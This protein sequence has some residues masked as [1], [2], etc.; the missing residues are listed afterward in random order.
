MKLKPWSEPFQERPT[1]L[2]IDQALQRVLSLVKQPLEAEWLTLEVAD[3]RVL[4]ADIHST[5]V[6]PPF[7]NSA[8]DGYALRS[9]D[10]NPG[11]VLKIVEETPAGSVSSH[12][13]KPGECIRIFT[14]APV[15]EGC[16]AVLM[17]EDAERNGDEMTVTA[18]GPVVVGQHIRRRGGDVEDGSV[19]VRAGTVLTPGEI[20]LL[21]SCG[22][23]GVLVRRRPRVAIVSTGHEL[24]YIDEK[25]APGQIVNSN[26]LVL[27][28]MVRRA[29]AEPTQFAI[30]PDTRQAHHEAFDRAERYDVILTSGGVSVGDHDLI[31]PVLDERG[32]N[33]EFWKVAMKPGKPVLCGTLKSGSIF[34]GLPGNPA[35]TMVSFEL[36]GRPLLRALQGH[37]RPYRCQRRIPLA[38][39]YSKKPGRLHVVRGFYKDG[40][41]QPIDMQGSGMLRSMVGISAFGFLPSEAEF[42]AAGTPIMTLDLRHDGGEDFSLV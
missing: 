20:G 30:V 9:E 17:Q 14:G 22:R 34:L 26:G 32:W 31:Q 4:A 33:R 36:F 19:L 7:D 39:D 23:S 25:P 28:N 35:S 16:D 18:R 8:M 5:R 29:G 10:G 40:K 42:I 41:F 24:I 21:A 13:L 6:L 27:T 2:P 11:R 38:S 3:N 12:K 37:P 15:P 1:M